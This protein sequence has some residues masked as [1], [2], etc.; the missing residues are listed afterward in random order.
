MEPL[1]YCR[2]R[3]APPGS[4]IYYAL[5][6]ASPETRPGLLAV[7]A[8][9]NEIVSIPH[10]VTDSGVAAVKLNWWREE[11]DR[12]LEGEG[13]H[14]V[15]QALMPAI[16]TYSLSPKP[17]QDILEGAAMDLEYGLYPGFQELSVYEHRTAGSVAHL[18]VEICGYQNRG[19]LQFAHDAGMGLGLFVLL[20]DLRQL[21]DAGRSYI[22]ED[23]LI[24]AGVWRDALAQRATPAP[25]RDLL[26]GQAERI[27]D[28]FS[29]A[30]RR[31][32]DEDRRAQRFA[33]IRIEL[34]RAL[35]KEMA[36]E[37]YPLLERGFELTPIRKL[38]V[39]WRTARRNR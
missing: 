34:A 22:P 28:F 25:I 5:R 20:R 3:V 36:A 4:D 32:P 11:L 6:F 27:E 1:D 24:D 16:K 30:E 31:L 12:A 29:Q 33:L 10:E 7:H 26:R 18:V 13:R 2:D 8:Y 17:F 15:S 9:A 39:A 35:L 37:N 19:T 14:P 23:E 38:W 21:A